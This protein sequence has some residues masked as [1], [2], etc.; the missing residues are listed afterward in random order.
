MLAERRE[1]FSGCGSPLELTDLAL[2]TYTLR[3]F[4]TDAAGHVDTTPDSYTW[5]VEAP[6]QPNTPAGTDVIV[7]LTNPVEATVTFAQVTVPGFTTASQLQTAPALPEGYVSAGAQYYDVSTTAEYSAPVTVCLP[8][9]P[10]HAHRC[11]SA[12]C[13]T[14]AP[15]GS[16]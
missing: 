15:S 4:A 7:E 10:A 2:G 13:T 12:C 3:V 11:R 1:P 5:T 9:S 6:P 16:T 8:Y 14:T